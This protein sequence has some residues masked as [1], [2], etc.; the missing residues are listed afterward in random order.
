VTSLSDLAN[1]GVKVGICVPTAPCGAVAAQIFKN[2]KLT[3]QPKASLVDVK[4]T[5]ATV[6]SGEVD[7]GLVYVTDVL[8]AGSKVK[9]V[10]IPAGLNATT[11]YPIAALKDAKN[12]ALAQAFVAY[13]LSPA[14]RQVLT[15]DG[16]RAP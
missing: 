9:G 10:T 13:V 11:E 4:T 5:L 2:A 12:P 7:A 8:A 16:F 15:A 14:G 3:V 1:S 6:E